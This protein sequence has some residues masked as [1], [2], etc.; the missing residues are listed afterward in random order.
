MRVLFVSPYPP[1]PIRVRPYS[2]IRALTALGADVHLVALVPPEDTGA[3]APV[4]VAGCS[5]VEYYPVSR[6]RTLLNTGHA[7]VGCDPMQARYAHSPPVERRVG[8]LA[9]NG[10]F[11]VVHVEHLRGV[12]LARHA[13]SRPRVLDA[14]DAITRL[15]A[16]AMTEAPAWTHRQIARLELER[17]RRF[18]RRLPGRFD[19]V[20]VAAEADRA[21]FV[22]LAGQDAASHVRVLP[23]GV[24][25]SRFRP[26]LA[27]RAG[28]PT[29]VFSAKQ[30]YHANEAA[31]RSLIDEVMPRVWSARPDVRVLIVGKGPP[32]WL[33][34]RASTE[35]RLQVTGAVDD[36]A[37]WLNRAWVAVCPLRYAVGIQNKVLEAMACAL[38]VVATPPAVDAL[39]ARSGQHFLCAA[40]ASDAATLVLRLIGRPDER[41]A[42]GTNARA[43]VEAHHAWTTLARGLLDLYG[44]AIDRFNRAASR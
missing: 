7:L 23:N 9:R 12:V 28:E 2:W 8:E 38:P 25:T 21:A 10:A 29:V 35:P 1:S 15:F 27:A 40:D 4:A 30:S 17:T 32:R 11:D 24:D 14:V 18:E 31:V 3:D 44:D 26:G 33:R 42:L 43:Y 5:A 20:A 16:Q 41:D 6:A 37:P 39:G 36:V 13:V 19:G 34:D 22:D